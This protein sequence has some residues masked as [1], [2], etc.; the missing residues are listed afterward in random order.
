MNIGIRAHDVGIDTVAKLATK[1]QNFGFTS[2]QLAIKK[3]LID[4]SGNPRDF[5]VTV[6]EEIKQEFDT[7]KISIAVLGAYLNY[8]TQ[9][10]KDLDKN[11]LMFRQQL[12]IAKHIGAS[13]IG[14]E[15]GSILPDYGY[16]DE[17]FSDDAFNRWLKSLEKLVAWAEEEKVFMGIEAVAKHIV[18]T[19]KRMKETLDLIGSSYL[20]VIFD[21]VNLIT[22]QNMNTQEAILYESFEYFA[23]K[24]V[25]IHAKDFIMTEGNVKVV[26]AGK[27]ILNYEILSKYVVQVPNISDILIE[28]VA[29]EH[30]EETYAFLKEIF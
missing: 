27:G 23:N 30:I 2:T 5:D 3:A 13:L 7:H 16:C 12:P 17:N 15:T 4:E 18:N 25:V 26:P 29:F 28:D 19:P 6:M 11:F 10:E 14:T 21:P 24:M 8:A 20:K 22:P 1:I 9:N